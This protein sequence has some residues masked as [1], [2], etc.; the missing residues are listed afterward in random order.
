ML[1]NVGLL[2]QMQQRV[3]RE[4]EGRRDGTGGRRAGTPHKKW[5][6]AVRQVMHEREER[7]GVTGGATGG[8]RRGR[9]GEWDGRVGRTRSGTDETERGKFVRW[10]RK[11]KNSVVSPHHPARA[12]W[13]AVCV[14]WATGGRGRCSRRRYNSLTFC[15]LVTSGHF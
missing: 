6:G 8:Q 15:P 1:S 11:R 14:G 10:R 5:R 9:T 3:K 13:P 7:G 4:N 2:L 12:E